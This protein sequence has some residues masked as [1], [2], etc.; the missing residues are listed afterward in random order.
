MNPERRGEELGQTV[1]LMTAGAAPPAA[2]LER[3]GRVGFHV[4][5]TYGLTECYGPN[6]VCAWHDEWVEEWIVESGGGVTY[7]GQ[8]VIG[9]SLGHRGDLSPLAN[10]TSLTM[11]RIR[12]SAASDLTAVK[13]LTNLEE[14]NLSCPQATDLSP[15]ARLT[16]LRKLLLNTRAT[17]LT[18][19]ENLTNIEIQLIYQRMVGPFFSSRIFFPEIGSRLNRVMDCKIPEIQE[20]RL[21]LLFLLF[22]KTYRPFREDVGQ[23]SLIL[24]QW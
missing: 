11:L 2:V 9:F 3:S 4:T 10:L 18:P 15:L 22:Q 7:D 24:L 23:V 1:R 21:G 16:K 12:Y 14:L 6:T 19:L 13:N 5:H 8:T 20:P 17:E